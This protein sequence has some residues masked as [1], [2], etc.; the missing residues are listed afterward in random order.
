MLDQ[1]NNSSVGSGVATMI[2]KGKGVTEGDAATQDK[3][4]RKLM[5][6]RH[7]PPGM[8]HHYFTLMHKF[9]D[10]DT[11]ITIREGPFTGQRDG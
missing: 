5:D 3:V 2:V 8:A 4:T 1:S 9:L 11:R 10:R 6:T 7:Y